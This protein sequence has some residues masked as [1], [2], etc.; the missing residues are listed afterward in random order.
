MVGHLVE[1]KKCFLIMEFQSFQSKV[2]VF[3]SFFECK[4]KNLRL[5]TNFET[6]YFLSKCISIPS[7]RL[8]W[9]LLRFTVEPKINNNNNNNPIY[10]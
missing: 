6:L 4:K 9:V 3:G 7:K 10:H 5:R 1:P 2:Y 8:K